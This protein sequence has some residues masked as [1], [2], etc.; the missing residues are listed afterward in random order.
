MDELR[1]GLRRLQEAA[2]TAAADTAVLVCTAAIHSLFTLAIYS[3]LLSV[4]TPV[5][6]TARPL[7]YPLFNTSHAPSLGILLTTLPTMHTH[8]LLPTAC[9]LLPTTYYPTPIAYHFDDSLLATL[10]PQPNT[11]YRL[12]THYWIISYPLPTALDPLRSRIYYYP[13]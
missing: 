1:L 9:R 5:T 7:S 4:F 12:I 11:E 2:A 13:R 3:H 6:R 10:Y 8:S